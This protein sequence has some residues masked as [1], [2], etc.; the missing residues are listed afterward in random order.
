MN[1]GAVKAALTSNVR[2]HVADPGWTVH[3]RLPRGREGWDAPAITF[4]NW[5]LPQVGSTLGLTLVTCRL[6]V[7]A[8]ETDVAGVDDAL[9]AW[10]STGPG[11]KSAQL[12]ELTDPAWEHIDT[13]G[14]QTDD[15]LKIGQQSY[16]A[17]FVGLSLLCP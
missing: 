6:I 12:A 8:S 1:F 11:T 16:R 14:A 7:V 2:A 9:D 15:D 3:Q 5:V 4:D 17:V 10:M 13:T